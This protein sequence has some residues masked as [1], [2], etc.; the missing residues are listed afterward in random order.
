MCGAVHLSGNGGNGWGQER[1]G[2]TEW[3]TEDK[4]CQLCPPGANWSFF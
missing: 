3:A 1:H 2:Y 4:M